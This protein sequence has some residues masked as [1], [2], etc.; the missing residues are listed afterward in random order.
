MRAHGQFRHLCTTPL[1]RSKLGSFKARQGDF[2]ICAAQCCPKLP[3]MLVGETTTPRLTTHFLRYQ[4]QC[5]RSA[6]QMAYSY[7]QEREDLQIIPLAFLRI[8]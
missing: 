1:K 3:Y 5:Y 4:V 2:F 6:G 8:L 7:I